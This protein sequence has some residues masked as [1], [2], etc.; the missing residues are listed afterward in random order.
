MRRLVLEGGKRIQVLDASK[1]DD[2]TVKVLCAGESRQ[3]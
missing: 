1:V 3:A 2:G